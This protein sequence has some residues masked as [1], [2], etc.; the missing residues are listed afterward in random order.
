MEVTEIFGLVIMSKRQYAE[1][2]SKM[3]SM[4]EKSSN[5]WEELA[6]TTGEL[7]QLRNEHEMLEKAYNK[8]TDRDEKGRFVKNE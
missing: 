8:L 4:R 7:A 1:I 5:V 2:E 3:A 6:K